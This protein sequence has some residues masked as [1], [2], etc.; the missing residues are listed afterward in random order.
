MTIAQLVSFN[1][2][3]SACEK[4]AQWEVALS[5]LREMP[6]LRPLPNLSA[7][8]LVSARVERGPVGGCFE[9]AEGN[10]AVDT[11]AQSGSF[12]C[13]KRVRESAQLEVG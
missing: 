9:H 5:M 4:R 2:G 7:S 12:C 1:V 13:Y 6:L 10:A 3:R 11:H 8:M